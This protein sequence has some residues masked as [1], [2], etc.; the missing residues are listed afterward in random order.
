[1]D[2]I[3]LLL[4]SNLGD[5]PA[6]GIGEKC[7]IRN[8]IIDKDAR[9]GDNVRIHG[10]TSLEDTDTENY[11]I[12]DTDK[13]ELISLSLLPS[14]NIR[15]GKIIQ[16]GKTGEQDSVIEIAEDYPNLITLKFGQAAITTNTSSIAFDHPLDLTPSN[17]IG[18][19]YS[20]NKIPFSLTGTVF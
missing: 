10:S 4:G 8:A 12:S 9:I 2:G 16:M 1:M 7:F 11:T 3:Y 20:L 13:Q 14:L 19:Y 18:A 17:I 6:M 15:N 5:K